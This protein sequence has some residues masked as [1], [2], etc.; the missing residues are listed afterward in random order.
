M[1][2]NAPCLQHGLFMLYLKCLFIHYSVP[3]SHNSAKC[4]R[5]LNKVIIKVVIIKVTI[6]KVI[7]IIVII[8]III[9]INIIIINIIIIIKL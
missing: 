5:H 7:I 9:G 2:R 8:I 6:I 3:S 1:P 4:I